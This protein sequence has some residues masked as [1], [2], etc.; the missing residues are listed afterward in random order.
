MKQFGVVVAFILTGL[1]F[2]AAS[3]AQDKSAAEK[4]PATTVEKT[5]DAPARTMH[6]GAK[7]DKDA[8]G[9]ACCM[10]AKDASQ[11]AKKDCAG[12]CCGKKAEPNTQKGD[13]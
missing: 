4:K 6:S 12:S 1:L 10:T 8:K 7:M 9:A 11:N 5:K 2:S 13:K 3:F